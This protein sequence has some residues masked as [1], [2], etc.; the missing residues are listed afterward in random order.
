MEC[1]CSVCGGE[2]TVPVIWGVGG[3]HFAYDHI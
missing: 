1:V 3:A 2:G